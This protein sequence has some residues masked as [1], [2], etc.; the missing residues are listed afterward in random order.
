MGRHDRESSR[1][2]PSVFSSRRCPRRHLNLPQ[3]KTQCSHCSLFSSASYPTH[4]QA[5]LVI[6]TLPLK[7]RRCWRAYVRMYSWL[8]LR[9]Q[10]GLVRGRRLVLRS[11]TGLVRCR[12]LVLR[13]RPGLTRDRPLGT[14]LFFS[15]TAW[16][17]SRRC[18]FDCQRTYVR[19]RMGDG[20]TSGRRHHFRLAQRSAK[21]VF[22]IERGACAT[23]QCASARE[24]HRAR[25]EG[26][27]LAHPTAHALPFD[28]HSNMNSTRS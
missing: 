5:H 4:R 13:S 21:C 2:W 3:Q 20:H 28:V 18:V 1:L 15:A 23:L 25:L 22:Q 6:P 17:R 14:T 8:V 7:R 9:L 16:L 27:P 11:R 24:Q 12:R 10:P 26:R 19:T